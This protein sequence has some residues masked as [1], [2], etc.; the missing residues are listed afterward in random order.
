MFFIKGGDKYLLLQLT[1][2]K[3][4][5]KVG[6]AGDPDKNGTFATTCW[7]KAYSDLNMD[8]KVI[9]IQSGDISLYLEL[10]VI[11]VAI[12]SVCMSYWY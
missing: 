2:L 3:V 10:A 6:C 7:W 9:F 4:V 5:I 12:K 8:T 1:V 11:K